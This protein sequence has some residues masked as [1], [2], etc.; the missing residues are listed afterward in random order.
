MINGLIKAFLSGVALGT[1]T[2]T[3]VYADNPRTLFEYALTNNPNLLQADVQRDSASAQKDIAI[4]NIYPVIDYTFSVSR[5]DDS[6]NGVSDFNRH[7]LRVQQVLFNGEVFKRLSQVNALLEQSEIGRDLARQ[8]LMIDVAQAYVNVLLAQ[9]RLDL[10]DQELKSSRNLADRARQRLEVGSGTRVDMLQAEADLRL[11]ESSLLAMRNNVKSAFSVLDSIVGKRVKNIEDVNFSLNSIEA[12]KLPLEELVQQV[13]NNNLRLLQERQG[14][15]AA[16]KGADAVA[17]R[18]FPTANFTVSW[19]QTEFETE[20]TSLQDSRDI[21]IQFNF[22]WVLYNG[23]VR[24]A[25]HDEAKA[26]VRSSAFQVENTEREIIAQLDQLLARVDNGVGQLPALSALVKAQE[27]ALEA[28]NESLL[29]GL[30]EL[31]EV[32]NAR[33]NLISAKTDLRSIQLQLWLDALQL[34]FLTGKIQV[35]DL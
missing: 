20:T 17:Q 23:G 24:Q 8:N 4:G 9:T 1:L 22:N 34:K 12:Y 26:L 11:S 7:Q 27:S 28:T 6:T 32:V 15:K 3:S 2:V 10:A 33:R 30:S 25:Q 18:I 14:I 31:I 21:G 19:L 13:K 5:D 29:V 35:E 16:N